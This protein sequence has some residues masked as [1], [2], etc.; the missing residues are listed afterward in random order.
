MNIG[1]RGPGPGGRA[2]HGN[3]AENSGE[4]S[5]VEGTHASMVVCCIVRRAR[6]KGR[7]A[8]L[9]RDKRGDCRAELKSPNLECEDW[10]VGLLLADSLRP[11]W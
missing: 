10:T 1:P 2:Y 6:R 4:Q 3:E 7:T 5:E 11:E 9:T 8:V